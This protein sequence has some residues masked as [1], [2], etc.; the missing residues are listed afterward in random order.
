MISVTEAAPSQKKYAMET[1]S[2]DQFWWQ[3]QDEEMQRYEAE[4]NSLLMLLIV[5]CAEIEKLNERIKF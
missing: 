3:Q 2:D 5:L 1:D 4:R